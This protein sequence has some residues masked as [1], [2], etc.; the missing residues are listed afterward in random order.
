[1]RLGISSGLMHKSASEWAQKQVE[2][3]ASSV[4]FPIN[5]DATDESVSEYVRAAKDNDL[6][7]AEVGVWKNTLSAD[8]DERKKAID[9]AIRQLDLADRIGANCC[10]NIL[11]TL[12]G[13]IWDG[14]YAGNF[15]KE[16]WN[17]GVKIIRLIID[18]VKPKNTVY[19]IEPMPWMYPTGPDEYL[20]LIDA[21]ERDS[22]GVHMDLVNMINCPQRY[23]FMD[24]FI[25]ECFEK[26]GTKIKSCH[27]KDIHLSEELTFRLEETSCGRG[28]FNMLKYMSSADKVS[29]EMPI[30]IEHLNTDEEYIDSM[31]YVKSLL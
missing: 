4:V 26:L 28:E 5:A 13:P 31:K 23:F 3:G 19:S 14:G 10:V 20:R 27:I 30:I 11:G 16:T 9:Y 25:D 29:A 6:L 12:S 24:E 22:F 1:M 2:I 17:E 7:I 18:V 21:V 8:A 15:S